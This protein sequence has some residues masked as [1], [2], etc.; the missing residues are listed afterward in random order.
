[1][2]NRI[3][4]GILAVGVGFAVSPLDAATYILHIGGM[5]STKWA[6]S[7]ARLSNSSGKVSIDANINT[8]VSVP[9]AGSQIKAR[10][11]QYCTGSNWCYVINYSG[12]DAN[13][14]YVLSTYNT[15]WN[16]AW[17]GT[18][19]GAGGGSEL[20]LGW[21]SELFTCDYTGDLWVST[22]RNMF[23][24]HDTNG[25]TIYHIAGYD[26]WWYSSWYLPGED[27]GAVSYHSSS[28]CTS[29]G[30]Y[31]N[32]CSCSWYSGHQVAW[33]CDGYDLDHYGMKMKFINN[34]G[35]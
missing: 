35:W 29:S 25:E 7:G 4:A 26:G 32:M 31:N 22:I 20:A 16:I 28:G 24:H 17:V 13:V 2:K 34:M 21:L 10:F 14:R 15:N 19:A 12:G 23:N 11:D 3:L 33:T 18:S 1:M 8:T 30:S 9:N 5:C 6:E 27:D